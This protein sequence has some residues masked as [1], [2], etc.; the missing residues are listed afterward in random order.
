[1]KAFDIKNYNEASQLFL[2]RW[3]GQEKVICVKQCHVRKD[4]HLVFYRGEKEI[5]ICILTLKESK[6]DGSC[7]FGNIRFLTK[8]MYCNIH[9]CALQDVCYWWDIPSMK[10]IETAIN[11]YIKI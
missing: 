6:N 10:R 2:N 11:N 4:E 9:G 7:F 8:L 1:M 3:I 5:R